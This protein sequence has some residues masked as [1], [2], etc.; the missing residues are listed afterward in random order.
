MRA[1][2]SKRRW[3]PAAASASPAATALMA[4]ATRAM[5]AGCW[6]PS[7][8]SACAAARQVDALVAATVQQR[9]QRPSAAK[10]AGAGASGESREARQ[11]RVAELVKTTRA[12]VRRRARPAAAGR[13]RPRSRKPFSRWMAL[14]WMS[15]MRRSSAARP[16]RARARR[17]RR[18]ARPVGEAG[19]A[20]AA[21]AETAR[22]RRLAGW[23]WRRLGGS[24][25]GD[26][27]GDCRVQARAR[28]D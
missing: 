24:R 19:E 25:G 3:P 5:P 1:R 28:G 12:A 23:R 20:E 14:D 8:I 10:A 18:A 4:M 22:R 9:L 13:A 27:G 11:A 2:P 16:Q 7:L 17:A 26:Q 6:H 21:E 15:R